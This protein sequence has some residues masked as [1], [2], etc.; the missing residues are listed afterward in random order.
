MINFAHNLQIYLYRKPVD[1]RKQIDG[2]VLLIC[3]HLKRNPTDGQMYLFRNRGGNKLKLLYYERGG[4]WLCYRRL[5]RGR[6]IFPEVL[7]S[8]VLINQDQL[9]WLLSGL[10]YQHFEPRGDKRYQYF[11]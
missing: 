11:H 3:D 4:F 9:Q 1:F 5:E 7:D 8:T 2:L 6:F 10:D